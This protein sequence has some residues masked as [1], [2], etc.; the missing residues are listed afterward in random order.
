[1]SPSALQESVESAVLVSW[2]VVTLSSYVTEIAR[3]ILLLDQSENSTCTLDSYLIKVEEHRE[4]GRK[5]GNQRKLFIS[6]KGE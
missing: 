2:S 4:K 3:V 5:N 1:M 6:R